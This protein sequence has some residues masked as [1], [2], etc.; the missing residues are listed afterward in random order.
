MYRDD[1][2]MNL[3]FPNTDP[4]DPDKE[5]IIADSE[6]SEESEDD[7]DVSVDPEELI[8]EGIDLM[9]PN[10]GDDRDQ[11][12]EDLMNLMDKDFN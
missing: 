6:E 5:D 3:M 11:L 2:K 10:D 1:E 8:K 7:D 4:D 12:E 9:L